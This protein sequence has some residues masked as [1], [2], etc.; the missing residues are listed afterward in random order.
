MKYNKY[1][2][3]KLPLETIYDAD[4]HKH[5]GNGRE[6][7]EEGE[8]GI[9]QISNMSRKISERLKSIINRHNN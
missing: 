2:D 7:T 8:D 9:Q 6:K 4:E 5:E 1:C 3:E